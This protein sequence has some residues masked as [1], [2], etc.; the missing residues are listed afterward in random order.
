MRAA[1]RPRLSLA[2]VPLKSCLERGDE[3][4]LDNDL[5]PQ[6]AVGPG[7]APA[8]PDAALY[9]F[10][11]PADASPKGAMALPPRAAGSARL[12]GESDFD[13]GRSAGRS[14]ACFTLRR[15]N[16]GVYFESESPE[17]A[18]RWIAALRGA[19][20]LPPNAF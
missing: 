3:D 18:Q 1:A 2:A 5:S 9:Y 11:S 13:R 17:D 15:G 10:V 14:G 16:K 6:P 12:M 8:Q 7:V 4:D 20:G 19:A